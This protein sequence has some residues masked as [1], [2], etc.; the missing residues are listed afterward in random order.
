MPNNRRKFLTTTAALVGGSSIIS[1]ATAKSDLEEF[2][3]HVQASRKLVN[4]GAD[5][6]ERDEYLRDRGAQ[7]TNSNQYKLS[8]LDVDLGTKSQI[9]PDSVDSQTTDPEALGVSYD[10][11]DLDINMYLV[12]WEDHYYAELYWTHMNPYHPDQRRGWSHRSWEGLYSRVGMAY[13]EDWWNFADT[14]LE[15]TTETSA[16][17][18]PAESE[19]GSGP[20]Y[21]VDA[22]SVD[23]NLNPERHDPLSAGVYLDPIGD[24]D[25]QERKIQGAFSLVWMDFLPGIDDVSVSFPAGITVSP[26]FGTSQWKT[27]TKRDQDTLLRVRQDDPVP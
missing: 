5:Q 11:E 3:E 8:D 10:P 14:S 18:E 26:S 22:Q 23:Y 9:E 15:E 12:E 19:F 2:K 6:S 20:S 21:K 16:L 27:A 1:T 24:Y 13:E 4:A 17:V 7:T 25:P